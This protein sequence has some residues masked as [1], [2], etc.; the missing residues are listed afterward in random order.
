MNAVGTQRTALH[1]AIANNH[2]EVSKVLLGFGADP[3][4]MAFGYETPLHLALS[5]GRE[6]IASLLLDYGAEPFQGKLYSNNEVTPFELAIT[7]SNGKLVSRMLGQDPQAPLGAKSLRTTK[8]PESPR[9]G[10]KTSKEVLEQQGVELLTTAAQRGQLEAIQALL[11][12]GVSLRAAMTNCP[13]ILQAFSLAAAKNA[14]EL[15]AAMEQ[16]RNSR[17]SLTADYIPQADQTFV[18]S[19]RRQE[20]H[21]AAKIDM[22]APER[23][24]KILDVLIQ[25]GGEYDAFSA[26]A[27]GD[28]NQTARLSA[29][30]SKVSQARDCRGQ[31]PLHWAIQTGGVPMAAFWITAGVPVDATNSCGQ[32]ALHLAAGGGKAD[33]VQALLDARAAANIRDTNGLTPLDVAIQAQQS[34]CIRLLLSETSSPAHPERGLATKLHESAAAGNLKVLAA[35]LETQTLLE[36]RD[37]LGLTPLHVAVQN[38]HLAAAALL[39]DKGANVNAQDPQGNSMLHQTIPRYFGFTVRDRPSTNWLARLREDPRKQG[40]LNYLMVGDDEQGPH[41]IM[42]TASFLLACGIDVNITNK[43]G[44]S[45]IQL[46]ADE[47]TVLFED[48]QPLLELLGSTGASFDNADAEGNT[49]L[50]HLAHVF[51]SIEAQDSISALLAAGANINATNKHGRTPLHETIQPDFIWEIWM[52]MLLDAHADVNA[53]DTNGF[54]PLHLLALS[55]ADYGQEEA[56]VALLKAGA[57]PDLLDNQGRTPLLLAISARTFELEMDAFIRSLLNAGANPNIKDEHGRTAAH[58]LLRKEWHWHSLGK[59]MAALAKAGADFSAVD[60]Q[61]RTPLHYLAGLGSHRPLALTREIGGLFVAA[62]V[63]FEARDK[64]GETPLQIAAKTGTRDV[65]DWLV[66]QGASLSTTNRTKPAR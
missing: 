48:R 54:T 27:L 61:G 47:K 21:W 26:T 51:F 65:F 4:R 19:L 59:S 52:R 15:P 57:K 55:K 25:H 33:V 46:A 5:D 13:T 62:K 43:A 23:W 29:A 1:Y 34:N 6:D 66:K 60:D 16:W 38:G 8:K 12:A 11:R 49:P 44:Q 17:A 64:A 50:H 7:R 53:Q 32:T 35:L 10:L 63:D 40:W 14:A 45:A 31:T 36:P 42:Q 18:S 30:D 41:A 9:R 39:V 2:L 20:A 28:T 24:K 56:A 58:L 22:M 37:E 3:N